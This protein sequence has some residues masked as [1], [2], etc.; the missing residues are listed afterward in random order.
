MDLTQT[1]TPEEFEQLDDETAETIVLERYRALVAV[2]L[3]VEAAVIF[4]VHPEIE[5][6]GAMD[7]LLRGCPAETA[8][9]IL[10]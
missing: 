9:R 6:P 8:L 2:G 5:L 4:A 7:L 1:I 10:R 3:D